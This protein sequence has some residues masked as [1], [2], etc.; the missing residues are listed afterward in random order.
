MK[1]IILIVS[2]FCSTYAKGGCIS[3]NSH[4]KASSFLSVN[5]K[6]KAKP[7]EIFTPIT[8]LQVLDRTI[9]IETYQSD[10]FPV[11]TSFKKEHIYLENLTFRKRLPVDDID[12]PALLVEKY[13]K[14]EIDFKLLLSQS[15]C[16]SE[17]IIVII[18]DNKLMQRISFEKTKN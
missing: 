12:D 10:Y 18:K 11:N 1:Y 15:D 16:L 7:T 14:P 9:W 6:W 13:N 2:V 5:S 8:S 17:I 3:I 4:Q